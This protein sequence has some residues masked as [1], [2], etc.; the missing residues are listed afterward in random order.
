MCGRLVTYGATVDPNSQVDLQRMF[1]RQFEVYGSASGS[2]TVYLRG[3]FRPV[4]DRRCRL[5]NIG[6]TFDPLERGEQFG[7]LVVT[8]A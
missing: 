3:G 6:A 4:I 5:A 1:I 7:K 8:M 2:L